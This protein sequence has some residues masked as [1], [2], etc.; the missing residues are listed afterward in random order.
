MGYGAG[1]SGGRVELTGKQRRALRGLGH[2]LK[3]VVIVGQRGVSAELLAKVET[4]LEHHELIKVKFGSE[5]PIDAR[6][7][8][9]P[10]AT[11]TQSH[12]A[13]VIGR[14][15]LL[16]RRREEDPAIELPA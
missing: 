4:E 6:D 10:L 15:I 5:A 16:Y 13:Q 3:P 2:H 11:N 12:V 1:P 7:A 14:T 9:Q 8:A